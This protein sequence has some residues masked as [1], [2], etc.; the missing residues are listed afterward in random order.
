MANRNVQVLNLETFY[1]T[2]AC[3]P[4]WFFLYEFYCT[5][6]L[7]GY[8]KLLIIYIFYLCY[9]FFYF[10]G[11]SKIWILQIFWVLVL[12]IFWVLGSGSSNI[13]V[14]LP[15]G[16]FLPLIFLCFLQFPLTKILSLKC[17]TLIL[18]LP[19]WALAHVIWSCQC[20]KQLLL[21]IVLSIAASRC[22]INFLYF[23]F[24]LNI[25]A[26]VIYLL[27]FIL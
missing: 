6:P 1:C 22:P 19:A 20:H 2:L 25:A 9:Y 10:I 13:L 16:I 14:L 27:K 11:A 18:L 17:F 7:N 8:I 4:L 12:Q 24:F 21:Q 15:F 26:R 5:S 3:T 23:F